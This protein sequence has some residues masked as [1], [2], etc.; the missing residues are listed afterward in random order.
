MPDASGVY[1]DTCLAHLDNL[2]R[3]LEKDKKNS[4]VF[5]QAIKDKLGKYIK[6]NNLQISTQQAFSLILNRF[7]E[8]DLVINV[9]MERF[10]EQQFVD[11]EE[12]F[13][14]FMLTSN[15]HS[16]GYIK[17]RN[18][19]EN[20]YFKYDESLKKE[21][22]KEEYDKRSRPHYATLNYS[23]NPSGSAPGYGLAYLKL[24][25][26]VK[27]RCTFASNDIYE[28]YDYYSAYVSAG[29]TPGINPKSTVSSSQKIMHLIATMTDTQLDHIIGKDKNNH[30]DTSYIE[31]QIHS[32]LKW[33]EHVDALVLVEDSD[34]ERQMSLNKYTPDQQDKI[35]ANAKLF[36]QKNNINCYVSS[37]TG[38][39]QRVLHT[40]S[41]ERA[42]DKNLKVKK[43]IMDYKKWKKSSYRFFKYRSKETKKIDS[44]VMEYGV[45]SK[46]NGLTARLL[47][48][49][50]MQ[51]ALVNWLDT[52]K[53]S[54]RASSIILLLEQV[55][56]EQNELTE[57]IAE[58]LSN[59]DPLQKTSI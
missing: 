4:S 46:H 21:R 49:S 39:T 3:Q 34:D 20:Y 10:L 17:K 50:Q 24:K 12:H 32:D 40:K 43:N 48:A 56:K 44:L 18:E 52:N 37:S 23:K 15:L 19:A 27:H 45:V 7:K 53:T 38:V 25:K 26:E 13:N 31:A 28:T 16:D 14:A 59:S 42:P 29:E 8:S 47:L 51:I 57:S 54:S 9:P 6:K 11:S 1:F 55:M 35:I 22:P 2:S 33:R 30:I 5:K 41:E 36:A 58:I